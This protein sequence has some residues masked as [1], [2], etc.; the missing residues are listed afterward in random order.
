[1]CLRFVLKNLDRGDYGGNLFFLVYVILLS[2]P[3]V[4]FSLI[5]LISV[6]GKSSTFFLTCTVVDFFPE[7]KAVAAS[8]PKDS[9]VLRQS[10]YVISAV[11]SAALR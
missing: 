1:M 3:L 9:A 11:L 7:K 8:A 10:S 6:I 2:I 4:V 5:I